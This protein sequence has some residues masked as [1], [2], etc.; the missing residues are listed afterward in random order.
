VPRG[1]PQDSTAT[2]YTD[3]SFIAP[4]AGVAFWAAS[5]YGR[6][7]K[8]EPILEPVPDSLMAELH[9][10]RLGVIRTLAEWPQVKRLRISSDSKPALGF[11]KGEVRSRR[12][13]VRGLVKAI[14]EHDP[15]ATL[16]F[17]WVKGHQRGPGTPAHVNRR[18]DEM[19]RLALRQA[20]KVIRG[21]A[22]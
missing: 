14:L 8:A 6:L 5:R 2:V 15:D 13:E 3:A 9:A 17:V 1:L 18:V 20:Q 21:E 11:L 10:I 7:I 19:A 4:A 12:E 16:R 22:S